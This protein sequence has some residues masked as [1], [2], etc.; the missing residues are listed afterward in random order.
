MSTHHGEEV[1]PEVVVVDG[2]TLSDVC[3]LLSAVAEFARFADLE[4]VQQLVRFANPALGADGLA[5]IADEFASRLARR[6]E[7]SPRI[8]AS[9]KPRPIHRG[10]GPKTSSARSP[11][12]RLAPTAPRRARR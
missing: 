12:R 7:T 5:K 8:G 10:V 6:V 2:Y 1:L 9:G 11:Q 4:A 3:W